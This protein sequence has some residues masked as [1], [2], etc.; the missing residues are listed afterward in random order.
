MN[1]LPDIREKRSRK[2][3]GNRRRKWWEAGSLI[4]QVQGKLN[5]FLS[6]VSELLYLNPFTQREEDYRI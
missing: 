6:G 4:W 5:A 1:L 3:M 2:D